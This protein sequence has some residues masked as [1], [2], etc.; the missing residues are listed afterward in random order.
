MRHPR[1]VVADRGLALLVGLDLGEGFGVRA[2]VVLDRDLRGHAAHRV[3]VAPMA[4]LDE[5]LRVALH[6]VRRHRDERASAR[7]KSR[8]LRSFLMQ[9]KM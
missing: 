9:L 1:P 4:G 2:L 6:E 5:E 7:Q 8:L 3:R